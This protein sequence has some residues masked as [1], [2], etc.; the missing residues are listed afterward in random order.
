MGL[1]SPYRAWR[2]GPDSWYFCISRPGNGESAERPSAAE[3]RARIAEIER[4]ARIA[5]R[6]FDL[7]GDEIRPLETSAI[8]GAVDSDEPEFADVLPAIEPEGRQVFDAR[9]SRLPAENGRLH[10]RYAHPHPFR[11]REKISTPKDRS[12]RTQR[13]RPSA[14]IS[15]APGIA[16]A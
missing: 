6:E 8:L 4:L 9:H 11:R 1:V 7:D 10:R 5:N 14:L 16:E 2:V 13:A 3:T 12:W 15:P